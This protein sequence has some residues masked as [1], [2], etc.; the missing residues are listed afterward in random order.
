MKSLFHLNKYF[1]RYKWHVI[2]GTFFVIISVIFEVFPA[3][4]VRESFNIVENAISNY[5]EGDL[6]GMGALRNELITYG[7]LIIGASLLQGLFMFFMRQTLIVMSRHIEYDLKNEVY[8]HYQALNL[9]FYKRNNTGDLMNRISEDVSRVRMYIGPAIMYTIRTSA[10]LI[11]VLTIMLQQNVQLTLLTLIPLPLLAF[12]IYKISEKINVRSTVVQ[13]QLSVLST[14]AQETFS[15]IRVLKSYSK[16]EKQ[17]ADF[18]KEAEEY[19]QRNESLYRVNALFFP[20]IVLLIGLSTLLVIYFGGSLVIAQT[21]SVGV[22]AE[23]IIYVNKLT[24]P[25]ASLGWVTSIVQRAAA[26]QTRINEFLL[27]EPEIKNHIHLDTDIR[28]KIEFDHVTFEYPDSGIVALKDLSFTVNPGETLAI[29]GKTGSG[30]ST[31]AALVGRLY[32]PTEGVVKV[33]DKPLKETNLDAL[34]N[35]MGVVPQEA[36]L[37]SDTLA[38]NISFGVDS[39]T[40]QE[41]EEAARIAHVDANIQEF[42]KKYDT[43]VGERGVTLSGGQKQRVSIARAVLAHPSILIFDD[44]LSAVDTETEEIILNNLKSVIDKR[45]T[46]IISHRA[47]SVKNADKIIVLD[48]GALIESGTHDELLKANGYYKDLYEKQL[49]EEQQGDLSA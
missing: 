17:L 13:E 46:L 1:L 34:R 6:S 4:Y 47:S 28:G 19:N 18:A 15:G 12:A 40:D 33:D 20:I 35:A 25:V 9:A 41:V 39:A 43:K 36:F 22:I 26:S 10:L 5:R 44:S 8:Q 3:T 23:F 21:I 29:V 49:M 42:P 7:L 38:N 27:Q 24:W 37:F 16:E 11:I 48:D 2:T 31:V 30:K 45:T 32:D 14:F